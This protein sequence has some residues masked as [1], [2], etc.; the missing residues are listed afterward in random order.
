MKDINDINKKGGY[1]HRT[2]SMKPEELAKCIISSL[3][4]AD[5]TS[6]DVTKFVTELKPY[7]FASLAVDLPYLDL[8]FDLLKDVPTQ[9]TT[10]ASYPLGGMTTEVKVKQV[11][12]ARQHRAYDID[13]S[14]NY[15]AIKSGDFSTVEEEV[16]RIVNTAGDLK[17][18][19]IPQVSILTNDEKAKTCEALLKGGCSSIKT[20][21]GFGW[22]TEV[23]SIVFIKRLFGDDI[24]IEVS[25]GVRTNQDAMNA[26]AA[27]AEK[28]H[29]STVFQ[30]LG[31]DKELSYRKKE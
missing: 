25:G 7:G 28:I 8:T 24:H 9:V 31:L 5:V 2:D 6:S 29:T 16:R 20:A 15:L 17:I 12:Y 3:I 30:V 10:V 4:E 21:S 13:V 22:K 27:G 18:V 1:M 19:M 11:E 23:E 14:M 26:L